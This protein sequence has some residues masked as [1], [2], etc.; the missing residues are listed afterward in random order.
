MNQLAVRRRCADTL[1][2]ERS[3]IARNQANSRADTTC[4]LTQTFCGTHSGI[5]HE[6]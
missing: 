3:G 1:A 5:E 6:Y 4:L 2:G